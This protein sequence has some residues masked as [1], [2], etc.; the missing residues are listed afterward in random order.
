VTEVFSGFGEHGVSAEKVAA[1]AIDEAR[2]YLG[3]GV[4]VGPHLA[5]QLLVPLA[6]AG[7]GRFVTMPLTRHSTTNIEVIGMFLKT[8]VSVMQ[9]GRRRVVVAIGEV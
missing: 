5:D 1:Q 9:D 3:A 6:L 4:P 8:P 2:D 7:R